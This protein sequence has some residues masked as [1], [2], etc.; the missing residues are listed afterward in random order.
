MYVHIRRITADGSPGEGGL[1][2]TALRGGGRA[3]VASTP[4]GAAV[5]AW[6]GGT[7][8]L[9]AVQVAADG[10]P[11]AARELAAEADPVSTQI[12]VDDA[13]RATV[14]WV[15]PRTGGGGDAVFVRRLLASGALSPVVELH[16][17]GDST[18]LRVATAPDG[19]S[20]AL[21][22]AVGPTWGDDAV[23]VARIDA[24]GGVAS[25]PTERTCAGRACR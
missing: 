9:M 18:E 24:A 1:V 8:A 14:A 4:A 11:G 5:V 23:W 15:A 3:V 7:G 2:G 12:A 22:T 25:T 6:I 20:W 17:V 10:R 19:T 21:W 13:G 16:D